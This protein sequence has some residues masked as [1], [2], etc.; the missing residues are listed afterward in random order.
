MK[1]RLSTAVEQSFLERGFSR[2]DFGR[3]ALLAGAGATMPFFGEAALAQL[4]QVKDM[5]ADAVKINANENPL[6]PAPE[7]IEAVRA[8]LAQ[9]GRYSYGLTDAFRETLAAQSGLSSDHVAAFPGSSAPLTQSVLAFTSPERSFVVCDP[10]YEAGEMAARF[11]GAKVTRVPLTKNYAHD[12]R[13]MAADKSAG[14]IYVCNPNNPT[15]TLTPD[16]DI[17]WLVANLPDG[18]VLLLDEAYT[19]VTDAPLRNDLVAAGKN[20]VILRTFSKIYG[21]AGLRAGAAIGRPDLLARIKP[22]SSGALP[23]TAMAAA[24]ASL[25]S[26]DLVPERRK[27]IAGV[28]RDVLSFLDAHG[29]A[30]VPSVSNK[31]M[32]DVKRPGDQ[33]ILALRQEKIYIGRV[34]PAWPTHVRVT[35]G[36]AEEMDKFKRAFLK[37]MA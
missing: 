15:G 9:G 1:L 32:V 5:P 21:M 30:Y 17:D 7:A 31:F 26:P 22:F 19:H 20:V 14:L 25:K 34:W 23:I 33:I 11:I 12:V 8:V 36:T 27:I 3:I 24:T 13:A 37:V 10:G 16:A 2:R 6:G 28:R 4:S 35:V 18:C 29:F